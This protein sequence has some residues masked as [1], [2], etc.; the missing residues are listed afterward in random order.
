M[1]ESIPYQTTVAQRKGDLMVVTNQ[2]VQD[3]QVKIAQLSD[4]LTELCM[5]RPWDDEIRVVLLADSGDSSFLMK[6]HLGGSPR[7]MKNSW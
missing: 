2:P 1:K 4:E 6:T 7:T 5:E 3:D